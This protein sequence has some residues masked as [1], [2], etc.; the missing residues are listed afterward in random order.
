MRFLPSKILCSLERDDIVEQEFDYRAPLDIWAA[1]LGNAVLDIFQ[2]DI[3]SLVMGSRDRY[4]IRI[5]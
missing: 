1:D 2:E 3:F 4:R 5:I